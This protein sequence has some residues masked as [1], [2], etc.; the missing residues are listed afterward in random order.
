MY[1]LY[2]RRNRREGWTSWTE[3]NNIDILAYNIKVIESYGWQW[4]I[5]EGD[6]NET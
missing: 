3:T 6:I 1:K 5:A 2:A 4:T